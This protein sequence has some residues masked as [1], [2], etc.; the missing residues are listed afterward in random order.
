MFAWL[1]GEESS[2]QGHPNAKPV[3]FFTDLQ[4]NLSHAF[5]P[6]FR[7]TPSH[8]MRE[9]A[10]CFERVRHIGNHIHE[11]IPLRYQDH[12]LTSTQLTRF[13][14]TVTLSYKGSF[15]ATT[16]EHSEVAGKSMFEACKEEFKCNVNRLLMD[17]NSEYIVPT[18]YNV[19]HE[20]KH[21]LQKLKINDHL[22]ISLS[23]YGLK[24]PERGV[25]D[26]VLT[27]DQRSITGQDFK[28]WLSL[29]Q[30]LCHL[31]V[32]CD[33]R[34]GETLM[35]LPYR[36]RYHEGRDLVQSYKQPLVEREPVRLHFLTYKKV[37]TSDTAEGED[38][39]DSDN[40]LTRMFLHVMRQRRFRLS[41]HRMLRELTLKMKARGCVPV[42]M[43]NYPVNT[44]KTYYAFG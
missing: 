22:L 29:P 11:N 33:I 32:L 4:Q 20:L 13:S 17:H 21:L 8:S 26:R 6:V 15:H 30:H 19:E 3:G 40:M 14:M 2:Y 24:N 25:V 41:I 12:S 1:R 38:T 37:D 10:Y 31:W 7:Y 34:G 18:K 27:V 5:A 42:F 28:E 23:G 39:A 43:S 44:K 35:D 16:L 9:C 36:Y